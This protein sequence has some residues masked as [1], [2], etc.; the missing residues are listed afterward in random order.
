MEWYLQKTGGGL[1]MLKKLG[2]VM[3]LSLIA[4]T[5]AV[6]PFST[7]TQPEPVQISKT[8]EELKTQFDQ[9][10]PNI[11]FDLHGV[12]V[13]RT[14]WTFFRG[15]I[16]NLGS[17]VQGFDKARLAGEFVG[18]LFNPN[19]YRGLWQL[20]HTPGQGKNKVTESYFNMIGELGYTKLQKELTQFANNIFV[21]NPK[22]IPVLAQLEKNCCKLHLLSNVGA[23]TFK[24]AKDRNLF[25]EVLDYFE[26]NVINSEPATVYNIW[27]PQGQAFKAAL[28]KVD[29]TADNAIM[30][31]DKPVNLPTVAGIAAARR[32][33]NKKGREYTAPT[34][35]AVGLLYK[36][37]KHAAVVAELKQLGLLLENFNQ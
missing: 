5:Q 28:E 16:C 25:P 1:K 36:A 37:K 34:P 7:K 3:A 29:A 23:N 35:W 22:M 27:K 24:D 11:F 8:P 6:W 26:S 30:I 18:V 2:M 4:T 17:T 13:T 32:K 10:K 20:L 14:P 15:G 21:V 33:A 31:E 9:T 12:L 19:F